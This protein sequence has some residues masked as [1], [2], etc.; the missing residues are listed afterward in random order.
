MAPL[1]SIIIVTYDNAS[2]I[3]ECL[4]SLHGLKTEF[5]LIIIDN[6]SNDNTRENI[7]RYSGRLP[8]KYHFNSYNAGFAEG[9]NQGLKSASGRFILLLGPDT[10]IQPGAVEHLLSVM[11]GSS[12]IGITAPQ[13]RSPDG[14]IQPSCRKFPDW[15]DAL[16]ELSGLPRL[17]S[18]RF[19]PAWKMPEFNHCYERDVEQPEA[20]CLLVSRRALRTVGNMDTR[21]TLFF[22]DVDWCRRFAL[23]G[24][25]AVFTPGAVVL[26]YHGF[27]VRQHPLR[28]IWKSH[29]GF[30]RF[31]LKYADST[32]ETI[33]CALLHP[34]F[35]AAAI[36]RSAFF[37]ARKNF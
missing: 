30:Y 24:W 17:F 31:L 27:S 14:K 28:M 8:L 21:F 34:V 1:L 33:I 13:L 7:I 19:I 37:I 4:E 25:R 20:S 22:N 2:T 3:R 29:Q 9:I 23:A 12:D 36:L 10:M 16:F 18:K 15:K 26:H 32:K 5:E 35:I 6:L 11:R